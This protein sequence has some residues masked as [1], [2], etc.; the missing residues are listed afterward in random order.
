MDR[1]LVSG[2]AFA[3]GLTVAA[4]GERPQEP[5][6]QDS[7]TLSNV[8]PAACS[9]NSFNSL[10][11][12]YFE[13]PQMQLVK[14]EKDAMI[15]A[16]QADRSE[17]ANV[18]GFNILRE[19][20]LRSKDTPQPTPSTGSALA[21][22]V[23]ECIYEDLRDRD[24][25]EATPGPGFFTK[26]LDRLTGGGFE[27][28]GGMGDPTS[29]I[30][31]VTGGVV[32]SGVAPPAPETDT[33]WEESL[34]GQ[35]VLFYGEPEGDASDP[36]PGYHWAV[37]PRAAEF[38]PPL[39][40]TTCVDDEDFN[41]PNLML[42]ES[43]VG[44]LA[45][46]DAFY[47]CDEPSSEGASAG[48]FNFLRH[49]ANLGRKLLIPEP[50]AAAAVMPGTVGG[51][52]KTAKSLFDDQSVA[53]VGLSVFQQPP[54]TVTVNAPFTVKFQAKTPRPDQKT[55]NGTTIFVVAT[56]NNGVPT[57]L[58]LHVDGVPVPCGESGCA[59]TTTS[60]EAGNGIAEFVLSVTKSGAVIL[61]A[62]GSVDQRNTV[63]SG[64]STN[65][66][67]VKP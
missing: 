24:V 17:Q 54:K 37:V 50:V 60:T 4:C 26:S 10:I 43:G 34:D 27:V 18:H 39:V 61:N 51:S 64:T 52:A 22:E 21:V 57:N 32:I 53:A 29:I 7:S 65:K 36:T 33:W 66:I 38:E 49:L 46:V 12:G 67:N 42:T 62:S 14:S 8:I 63:V 25:I 28:R 20:S 3:A 5:S 13:N 56:N 6:L 58:V 59:V 1:R 40:F 9:P 44:V 31:A 2:L 48:R 23:L 19:I 35:R 55:V 30:Q 11:A 15:A 45:F 41:D 16:L 47:I